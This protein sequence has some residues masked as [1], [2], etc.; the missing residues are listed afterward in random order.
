MNRIARRRKGTHTQHTNRESTDDRLFSNV[1]TKKA[2]KVNITEQI[3]Y[4]KRDVNRYAE[5]R[6]LSDKTY[7]FQWVYLLSFAFDLE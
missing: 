7:I 4:H 2:N 5:G 6:E 3:F 1:Q